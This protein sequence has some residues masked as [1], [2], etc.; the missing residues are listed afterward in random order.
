MSVSRTLS[1]EHTVPNPVKFLFGGTAGCCAVMFTQPLDLVKNR[2][3]MSGIGG[4]IKEHKTSMHV[5]R[6]IVRK[7]G[8]LAIYN[9]LSAGFLRQATYTCGRLGLYT[10][11]FERVSRGSQTPP[12]FAT[13]AV[14]GMT[15]GGISS[16]VC[17]P[18]EVSLIRMTSDGRLPLDQRRG[19]KHVFDALFRI[20]REEGVPALWRGCGPTILRAMVVNAAQLGTYSQAKQWLIQT[21]YFHETLLCYLIASMISG[22]ATT[23]VSM[24]VDIAK[25]RI[26]NMKIVN[27][28]PE[29][30]NMAEVWVKVVRKEGP[31]ALWKGF[32]PYYMRLGPHTVLTLVFL[33]QLNSLYYKYVLGVA[34]T[35]G[36]L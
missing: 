18:T 1:D 12:S 11:L 3:Q 10:L 33:E 23:A 31:F 7:E 21:G 34:K 6:S 17:T 5:V 15:A 28:V 4:K 26:Q 22:L 19:Y 36:G 30:K 20:A 25:T 9:G 27:G 32:T 2:M 16:L 13:K 35:G 14:L 8:F 29:Y 24:P